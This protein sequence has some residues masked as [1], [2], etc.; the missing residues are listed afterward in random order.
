MGRITGIDANQATGYVARV[1]NAQAE[2]WGAPLNNHL[3]YAHRPD[4]F[5]AVRGMWA[6]VDMDG[7]I[8]APLLSLVNRRIARLNGCEF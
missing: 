1:L 3:V 6:A 4:L 2:L 7:L 8:G 5:K